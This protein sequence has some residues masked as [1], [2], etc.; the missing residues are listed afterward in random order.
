[1][2]APKSSQ[3]EFTSE[4]NKAVAWA[5]SQG[6]SA[7]AYLPVYQ[8]DSNRL[9]S[10]EYPM[11]AAERNR[12]ILAAANPDST[13]TP[14]P[15][16]QP[17]S[18]FA[19]AR[20]DLGM[21]ATGLEPQ[22][23]VAN[24]F[25]T[26]TNTA[27]D[28]LDPKRLVGKT[29]DATAANI[30][31]DTLLSFVPG[32]Y[33]IG[34]VLRS[35][36]FDALEQHP[37]VSL[38]D[39]LPAGS[40]KLLTGALADTAM[41]ARLAEGAG[42][43]SADAMR[44]ANLGQVMTKLL[45]NK[46]PD[47][48]FGKLGVDP[49]SAAGGL[50]QMSIG[51]MVQSWLGD[52]KIGTS[53][54]VQ[55][56]AGEYMTNNQMYTAVSHNILE[57]A[58]KAWDALSSDEKRQYDEIFAGQARGDDIER[59]LQDPTIPLRVRDAATK[60]IRGPLAF[61]QE[62]A[63]AAGDVVMVRR[64]DGSTALYSS[65]Q[66]DAV[67]NARD[68]LATAR[69]EFRT[70]LDAT[71]RLR[72]VGEGID[73]A[74]PGAVDQLGKIN[75][76]ARQAIPKDESLHQNVIDDSPGAKRNAV[77]GTRLDM[78]NRLFGNGGMV[79][80]VIA[81]A[82]EH[83][84]DTEALGGM[85]G[86]LDSRLKKWGAY[87]V[88]A[89]SNPAFKAV[90]AR[91][92]QLT[93]VVKQRN[94]LDGEIDRRIN[95][96]T[97]FGRAEVE[98]QKAILTDTQ[99]RQVDAQRADQQQDRTAQ[100]AARKG[101]ISKARTDL[102]VRTSELARIQDMEDAEDNA[103]GNNA[104]LRADRKTATGIRAEIKTKI[105]ARHRVTDKAVAEERTKY[106]H[107]VS[108]INKTWDKAQ[109]ALNERHRTARLELRETQKAQRASVGG[110]LM[111]Q[112]RDYTHALDDF[113]RAVY[114]NPSDEYRDMRVLVYQ[115]KLLE[116][117]RAA[118]IID[119]KE[120][121]LVEKSKWDEGRLQALREDPQKLRELVTEMVNDVYKNPENFDP[122]LVDA[123]NEAHDEA[124]KSAVTE[125]NTLMAQGYRPMWL[126][127]AGPFERA[128]FS[129]KSLI[130][131]GTP[132]V[133]VA[134][135]RSN[136][137]VNTRYSVVL[138]VTKAVS[139]TL[140]RDATIDFVEHSLVPRTVTGTR[141]R[142]QLDE[143]GL[144]DGQG[145][146]NGYDITDRTL[147]AARSIELAKVGLTKVPE[148]FF[149]DYTMPRFANEALYLP[150]GLV[151][152]LEKMKEIEAKGDTGIF[153]KTNKVFRMSILG[154]SPRYTA[155]I[156]F[157]GTF[158]LALRST[159][160]LPTMLIRASR[161][162]REGS[163]PQEIFRTP[164]QE[165]VTHLSTALHEL[166]WAGGDQLS[167]MAIQ[168]NLS[169]VQKIERS[170]VSPIHILK[171][172]A[173]LNYRFTNYAVRMQTAMAYLDYA[174]AAERRGT[175]I[176]PVTGEETAMT[177]E[178][179]MHEGMAHV[180]EVFGNL[181]SMS[182]FERS[183]AKN[184]M[185]FY[186]WTRHILNYVMSFPSDHP[187]RAMVL[188]LM[189]Y[190]NSANVP[191]G[192]PE[193]I[194]FLFFLGK[195]DAQGN[196]SAI[197]TRFMDPLRDVANY[198]TLGGWL[199]GLNPALLAPLA[200]MNPQ[201][202]YGANSLYPNV[203]Y[204][205]FYGIETASTQGSVSTGL[206]QF[207]PQLGALGSAFKAAAGYRTELASNPNSFYKSVFESLNIPMAQLQHINVKQIAATDEIARYNVAKQAAQ[208]AF[209]S[210]DFSS[211][212]GYSSVPN[213]LNPDYEISPVQLAAV[214]NAAAV[215]YPGVAPIEV[216]TPPPAPI[217]F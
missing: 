43:A 141:L 39:I 150:S 38:L 104:A 154:L 121:S 151:T 174:S 32:A 157:G 217:G 198:A 31:Q 44:E 153:D 193:R 80:T 211:L 135:A 90:A 94:W 57:P 139:Q 56:I 173:D 68:A 195:P 188:S 50:Q 29:G 76:A 111:Q 129:I 22:H 101:A 92:D 144:L 110:E 183:I 46:I 105:S 162:L 189:A 142:E 11:S 33:D 40:S 210:G 156:L 163:L 78:A 75:D 181:R 168:E 179:A 140:R 119:A 126:P 191:A 165:G 52:S 152:A 122:E 37:L 208:N 216:L 127:A 192:L 36:N 63:I 197:D 59:L 147:G 96:S 100:G 5:Q 107:I 12:A 45:T 98:R 112:M 134:H 74:L 117:D 26:V 62:E 213:P 202:V 203:T 9:Q 215:E 118:E 21:I 146:L 109:G 145:K 89:S 185:P 206:E 128:S 41:G 10:G 212:R 70:G 148:N 14:T 160:Y 65:K 182:P 175:F 172:A 120:K 83:P 133:D 77:L 194:Q 186:G 84:Q 35:G 114:D 71:D 91:V 85:L 24:L 205:Q 138:G 58:V 116:S 155:H 167:Q 79:D 88:D 207:I 15:A 143:M 130:G 115:E 49:G 4:W 3:E 7:N 136:E 93:K 55:K 176:D 28:I 69:V 125:I 34:S 158:L 123:V 66:T 6:I 161:A 201:I 196:V 164:T 204:D 18:V 20:N 190:E 108:G 209:S 184:I 177:K 47:G 60:M 81:H 199:Q 106:D 102:E 53:G 13:P 2:A 82:K 187:W 72:Q 99:R 86:V 166:H 131:K 64:P 178:R 25:D 159:P 137:L 103:L 113:H 87:S 200:I 124:T 30:L 17:S 48:R 169:L 61:V 19:N 95:G 54:P 171:S 1:M 214:Y 73:K 97:N 8:L 67:F 23:L 180:E 132:H 170:K 27:K 42:F 16:P 51:Q 149:G